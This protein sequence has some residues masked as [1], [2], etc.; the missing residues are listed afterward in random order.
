MSYTI[1][2]ILGARI[3][4]DSSARFAASDTRHVVRHTIQ[5]RGRRETNTEEWS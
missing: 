2:S 5:H 1:D 4:L 3:V